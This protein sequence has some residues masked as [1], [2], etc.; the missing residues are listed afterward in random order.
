MTL[1]NWDVVQEININCDIGFNNFKKDIF[2]LELVA[3]MSAIH[4]I[5]FFASPP[6][7]ILLF[8]NSLDAMAVFN[9][10]HA[11]EAIHNSPL[12]GVASIIL[13]TRIDL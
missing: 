11:N 6:K 12:L 1:T 4:H 10:L 3:I 13:H 2:F 5:R 8:T 7:H 9:S